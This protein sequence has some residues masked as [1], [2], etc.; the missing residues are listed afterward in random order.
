M[1][2]RFQFVDPSVDLSKPRRSAHGVFVHNLH[3]VL[4]NNE[5]YG[6]IRE[7]RL[8]VV[9]STVIDSSHRMGHLLSRAGILPDHLH[10]TLGCKIDE[11][12]VEVGLGYLNSLSDALGGISMYQ[13]GFFVGTFGEY[14]L[15]AIWNVYRKLA[16]SRRSTG[17]GP[18]EA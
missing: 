17:T 2:E 8:A 4:V 3:L 7:D 11:R 14:D 1:L 5:R 16:V 12:P 9:Y 6:E 18:V 15:G 10:L 13:N